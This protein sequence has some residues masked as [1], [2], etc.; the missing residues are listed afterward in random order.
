MRFELSDYQFI[1]YL[2]IYLL[3][4]TQIACTVLSPFHL[5]GINSIHMHLIIA[6]SQFK[7][8]HFDSLKIID[9]FQA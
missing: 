4:F 9:C 3:Y 7:L 2:L 8:T 1:V 6:Y 5:F